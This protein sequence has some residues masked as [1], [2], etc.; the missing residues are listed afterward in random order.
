MILF[1][2]ALCCE[3]AEA[4]KFRY[5]FSTKS[6]QAEFHDMDIGLELVRSCWQREFG[7]VYK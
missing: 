2:E 4:G 7:F 6:R 1:C 5:Q 3:R